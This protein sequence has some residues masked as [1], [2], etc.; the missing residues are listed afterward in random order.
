MIAFFCR[1]SEPFNFPTFWAKSDYRNL[2]LSMHCNVSTPIVII[3]SQTPAMTI[4]WCQLSHHQLVIVQAQVPCNQNWPE[5]FFQSCEED[6]REFW[7][8]FSLD[9]HDDEGA[10]I[11]VGTDRLN[12]ACILAFDHVNWDCRSDKYLALGKVHIGVFCCF[13]STISLTGR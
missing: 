2:H 4:E 13:A 6:F 10:Y 3:S 12:A 11:K 5:I 7:F 8:I 9:D 1:I